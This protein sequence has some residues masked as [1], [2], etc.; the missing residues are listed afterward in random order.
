MLFPMFPAGVTW[1]VLMSCVSMSMVSPDGLGA[2][3][4]VRVVEVGR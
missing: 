2:A 3:Q 4:G 1:C